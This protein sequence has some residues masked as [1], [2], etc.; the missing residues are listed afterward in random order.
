MLNRFA[1][2]LGLYFSAQFGAQ[3][4]QAADLGSSA[5]DAVSCSAKL[6]IAYEA[7][8]KVSL[9]YT[10]TFTR[11]VSLASS[12]QKMT[13]ILFVGKDGRETGRRVE[14]RFNILKSIN[15][16]EA[17]VVQVSRVD[18]HGHNMPEADGSTMTYTLVRGQAMEFERF[19]GSNEGH[20]YNI[21]LGVRLF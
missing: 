20:A 16:G 4:V 1:V 15:C 7:S 9:G 14:L 5:L 11:E 6:G 21:D 13:S 10:Q 12:E 18:F 17:A 8:I 3:A 19:F 2:V